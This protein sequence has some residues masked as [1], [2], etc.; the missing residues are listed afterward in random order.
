M[1]TI[2]GGDGGGWRR[3]CIDMADL[4]SSTLKLKNAAADQEDVGQF[5][6]HLLE[7]HVKLVLGDALMI[8]AIQ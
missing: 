3:W 7:R 4:H 5:L 1:F 2:C 6:D 8:H